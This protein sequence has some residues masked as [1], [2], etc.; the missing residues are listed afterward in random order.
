MRFIR[1][2][3]EIGAKDIQIAGGKGANLGELIRIGMPVPEGFVISAQ[4]FERFLKET[5]TEAEIQTRWDKINIGDVESIEEASE[6]IRSLILGGR[7]PEDFGDE[8]LHAFDQ[9]GARY[10]AVRSSATAEDT[11]IDSWAGEL[12]TYLNTTKEDLLENIKRCWASLYTPRAIFYRFGRK[13]DH[14]PIFERQRENGGE[15]GET[16]ILV[17]VVVQKMIQSEVSGVCF[18]VHPV[19]KDQDQMLI[20]ACWG[21]G[22]ILVSGQITPD[23]YVITKRSFRIL[24]VN[25]NLQERMIV[26]GGEKTQ[27]IPVPKFKR[28]KQKLMWAQIGELAKLCIKIEDHFKDPQD[29][30]WA[31]AQGKF[32]ILQSRLIT[33]L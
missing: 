31:L 32:H 15:R 24:D 5:D 10:V 26:S 33:T 16:R 7:F 27:A 14:K 29:V 30:E 11:K 21:L 2:L 4:A 17:A 18:T 19:T 22:E 1:D 6:I 3:K 9:L 20:E 28:E 23:S 25:N 8:I 13:L 12:E